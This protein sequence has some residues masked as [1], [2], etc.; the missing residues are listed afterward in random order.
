[1]VHGKFEKKKKGRTVSQFRQEISAFHVNLHVAKRFL[2]S[3]CHVE[4]FDTFQFTVLNSNTI[5]LRLYGLIMTECFS[6]GKDFRL[7][8]HDIFEGRK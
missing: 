5:K 4:D 2:Q 3:N 6:N 1:M 7:I 8:G